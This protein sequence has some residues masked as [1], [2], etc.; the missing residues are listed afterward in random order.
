MA[1][2]IHADALL[3]E[4]GGQRYAVPQ[5][6]VR[7]VLSSDASAVVKIERQ[8]PQRLLTYWRAYTPATMERYPNPG[9]YFKR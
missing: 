9:V 8:S 2:P 4:A 1:N 7:E 3:V 6:A 5:A